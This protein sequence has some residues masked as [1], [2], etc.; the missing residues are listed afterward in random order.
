MNWD[1]SLRLVNVW[2]DRMAQL[3]PI[4]LPVERRN[5]V[6]ALNALLKQLNAEARGAELNPLGDSDRASSDATEKAFACMTLGA[7][8]GVIHAENL[9]LERFEMSHVAFAMAAYR[10]DHGGYPTALAGLV[11]RYIDILPKDRFSGAGFLA[12]TL[13]PMHIFFLARI[14]TELMHR[15][16]T[17]RLTCCKTMLASACRRRRATRGVCC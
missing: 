3:P 11:P 5:A 16:P 12:A 10:I 6:T 17:Q 14:P 13:I 4:T 2:F 7:E 9:C 1:A 15:S 8:L